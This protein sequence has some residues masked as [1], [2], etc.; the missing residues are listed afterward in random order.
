MFLSLKTLTFDNS[1]IRR[2]LVRAAASLLKKKKN[3]SGLNGLIVITVEQ[4]WNI[5]LPEHSFISPQLS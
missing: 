1:S 5:K 4:H 3:I 2:L